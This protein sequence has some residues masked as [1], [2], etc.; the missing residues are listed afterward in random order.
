LRQIVGYVTSPHKFSR[1]PFERLSI[2]HKTHLI[3]QFYECETKAK[4]SKLWGEENV[5]ILWIVKASNL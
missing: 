1:F 3:K 2:G 5:E 4:P